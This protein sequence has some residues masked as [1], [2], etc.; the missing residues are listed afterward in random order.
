[1]AVVVFS[2]FDT[3]RFTAV[4]RKAYA[5]FMSKIIKCV[6]Y[7]LQGKS[8]QWKW[9]DDRTGR[10]CTYSVSNNKSIDDAY[11]AGETSIRFA[12]GRRRYTVQFHNM[13][14]VTSHSRSLVK[15]DHIDGLIADLALCVC[16]V[17]RKSNC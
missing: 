5:T 8:H 12:A 14:Q 2:I 1:M 4:Y 7:L 9:F 13:V 6:N 3:P 15:S 17:G 10:W 11:Q 16:S